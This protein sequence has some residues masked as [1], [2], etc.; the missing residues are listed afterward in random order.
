MLSNHQYILV[1]RPGADFLD[2]PATC[3]KYQE[4]KLSTELKQP[5]TVLVQ[6]LFISIDPTMRVW[7]SGIRT[8]I[9]V[10]NLGDIM[11]SLNIGKVIK[12]NSDKFHVG[13]IVQGM[14]GW[15]EYAVSKDKELHKLPSSYPFPEHFLNVF[16]I[17]GLTAYFGLFDIGQPKEGETVVV[18]TA[19]GAVGS[20]VVQ[21]AKNKGCRVV[22]IAGGE[23]KCDFV[24]KLG[25]DECIDYYKFDGDVKKLAGA[26]KTACPKGVDVYFDNVGGWMLDSVFGLVNNFARVVACGAISGYNK[27][28]NLDEKGILRNYGNV[29]MRR[30]TYKGFIY[31]DYA[32]KFPETVMELMHMVQDKKLK[33]KDDIT[34]GLENAPQALKTLFTGKNIGKTMVRIHPNPTPKL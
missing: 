18:S 24:K 9:G 3:F 4:V 5:G 33:F 6:N 25:A 23:K 1:K 8:Y 34:E 15:Q 14:S 11:P 7:M 16:G 32:K 20:I 29:I 17:N 13:D 2:N 22:G 31:F 19:A 12:S 30:V 26:L 27:D 28:G 21:L 10:L